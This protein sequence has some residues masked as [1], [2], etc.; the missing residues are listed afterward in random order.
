V[1]KGSVEQFIKLNLD[2]EPNLVQ[3]EL[4]KRMGMNRIQK[5]KPYQK[6]IK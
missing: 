1:R 6:R 4:Q 5:R 2:N 3:I